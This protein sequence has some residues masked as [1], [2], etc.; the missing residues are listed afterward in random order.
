M[1][2]A[3]FWFAVAN[4]LARVP[5]SGASLAADIPGGLTAGEL[6]SLADGSVLEEPVQVS[7]STTTTSTVIK[8]DLVKRYADRGAYLATLSPTRQYYGI[9]YDGSV[10]SA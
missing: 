6:S 7:Y 4:P 2:K 8:A 1:V 3:V 5:K 9:Y 10:W